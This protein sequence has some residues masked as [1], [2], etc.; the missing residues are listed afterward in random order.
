MHVKEKD[1]G[2]KN[3]SLFNLKE[4]IVNFLYKDTLANST[5]SDLQFFVLLH[6]ILLYTAQ[7]KT[8]LESI[9]DEAIPKFDALNQ[10]FQRKQGYLRANEYHQRVEEH[11]LSEVFK[12]DVFFILVEA[13]LNIDTIE[14][15]FAD[16]IQAHPEV[17]STIQR[18]KVQYRPSLAASLEAFQSSKIEDDRYDDD[19]NYHDLSK[20][21]YR[22]VKMRNARN[23]ELNLQRYTSVKQITSNSPINLDFLQHIDPQIIFDLWDKYH[24]AEYMKGALRT[25]GDIVSNVAAGVMTQLVLDYRRHRNINGA[26]NRKLKK[27]AKKVFEKSKAEEIETLHQLNL[28]LVD[29]VLKSQELLL[30]EVQELRNEKR[31]LEEKN[32]G[33][34]NDEA[35]KKLDERISRLENLEIEAKLVDDEDAVTNSKSHDQMSARSSL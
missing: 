2:T 35:I 25:T 7:N 5:R 32:M 33:A 1:K 20:S 10:T 30:R 15:Q 4:E 6:F 22:T 24:V 34:Q 16:F 14:Q 19:G 31:K 21:V 13:I 3:L 27:A 12:Y 8:F 18:L 9:L 28:R 17:S 11:G 26:K 23:L 29:S